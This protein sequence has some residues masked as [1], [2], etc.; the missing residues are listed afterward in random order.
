[1]K[2]CS[3]CGKPIVAEYRKCDKDG[4]YTSWIGICAWC[5][6]TMPFFAGYRCL[7]YEIRRAKQDEPV[8]SNAEL[9][10]KLASLEKQVKGLVITVR[11]LGGVA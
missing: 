5:L 11:E 9:T 6:K 8:K 2:V 7:S 3:H 4:P 1:M 10:K